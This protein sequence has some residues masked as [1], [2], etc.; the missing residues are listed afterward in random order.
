[1]SSK[2]RNRIFRP[3]AYQCQIH[4]RITHYHFTFLGWQCNSLVIFRV[5]SSHLDIQLHGGPHMPFEGKHYHSVFFVSYTETEMSSWRHL[6]PRMQRKLSFHFDI[7]F[8][9]CYTGSFHFIK[10]SAA[11]DEN[12]V[13][14]M[15]FVSVYQTSVPHDLHLVTHYERNYVIIQLTQYYNYIMAGSAFVVAKQQPIITTVLIWHCANG[16]PISWS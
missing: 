5:S 2:K 12:F 8:V 7:I 16:E 1:M 3:N 9:T 14:M 11:N 13:K 15:H 10:S 6:L 4:I